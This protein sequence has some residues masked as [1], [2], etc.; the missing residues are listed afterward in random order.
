[1]EVAQGRWRWTPRLDERR[2]APL[3][4]M[5]GHDQDKHLAIDD[6]SSCHLLHLVLIHHRRLTPPLAWLRLV[7]PPDVVPPMPPLTCHSAS[8]LVPTSY[9]AWR[10][11]YASWQELQRSKLRKKAT[12]GSRKRKERREE[13]N[14]V[15]EIRM[16]DD[17]P[18]D[19]LSYLENCTLDEVISIL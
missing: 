9:A 4:S 19:P 15:E 16:L 5:C 17:I 3:D 12:W 18:N 2:W 7:L 10:R 13:S 14:Q 6:T 11:V 1:L 8:P